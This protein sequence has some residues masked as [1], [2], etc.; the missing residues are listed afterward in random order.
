MLLADGAPANSGS[1]VPYSQFV[2]NKLSHECQNIIIKTFNQL[3]ETMH[4]HIHTPV[5]IVARTDVWV[6]GVVRIWSSW[7]DVVVGIAVAKT[8]E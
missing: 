1:C 8:N 2:G 5:N 7:L 3:L 4:K 6:F